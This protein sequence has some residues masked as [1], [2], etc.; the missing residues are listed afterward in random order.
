MVIYAHILYNVYYTDIVI[1]MHVGSKCLMNFVFIE[2]DR[3]RFESRAPTSPRAPSQVQLPKGM[4]NMFTRGQY[5]PSGRQ[6]N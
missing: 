4:E 6:L 2:S 3:E 1:Q 5:T